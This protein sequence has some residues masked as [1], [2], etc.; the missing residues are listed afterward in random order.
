MGDLRQVS[1]ANGYARIT[2]ERMTTPSGR[3]YGSAIFSPY[4]T[5]SQAY[6]TWEA[7]LRYPKGQGVWPA[8]FLLPVGQKSPYPEIDIFE[9]YPAPPSGGG[10]GVNVVGT[11]DWYGTGL[12]HNFVTDF[13][14]LGINI[15]DGAF[16]VWKMVWTPASLVFSVDETVIGS[17]TQDVP[18]VPMYPIFDLALGAPGY[19]VDG[20]TPSLLTMD[21]D[22]LRVYAP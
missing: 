19:R 10:S 7:R 21:I 22:Y 9:A 6:G 17:I 5:F 20:T 15:T 14:S 18:S 8:W 2:A 1:V 12:N 11:T 16:H 4:G 13:T 3:P